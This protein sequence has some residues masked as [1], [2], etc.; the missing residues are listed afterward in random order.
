L[1]WLYSDEGNFTVL[2]GV[3]DV[4]WIIDEDGNFRYTE[5]HAE[6]VNDPNRSDLYGLGKYGGWSSSNFEA[7]SVSYNTPYD[8][9]LSDV[10]FATANYT[11][12]QKRVLEYY[13]VNTMTELTNLQYSDPL[14]EYRTPLLQ[15]TLDLN[16]PSD[17]ALIDANIDT[18][19]NNAAVRLI[20]AETEEEFYAI[21]EEVIAEVKNM[22]LDQVVEYWQNMIAETYEKIA[23]WN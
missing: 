10:A 2:N 8:I 3:P 9:A 7:M 14:W 20:R 6:H 15:G 12:F 18:Y 16:L 21:R 22:G 13:G 23:S 5:A 11:D 1:N 17:L 19:M 4:E